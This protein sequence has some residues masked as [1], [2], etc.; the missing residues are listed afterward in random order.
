[1]KQN[2][3]FDHLRDNLSTERLLSYAKSVMC[4]SYDIT[5]PICC[6]CSPTSTLTNLVCDQRLRDMR[7]HDLC[8]S[9]KGCIGDCNTYYYEFFFNCPPYIHGS[10]KAI[11]STFKGGRWKNFGIDPLNLKLVPE[12][13]RAT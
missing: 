4:A 12:T 10:R 11:N 5:N 8:R 6:K 13:R 1:M 9:I 7:H 3:Y 2:V